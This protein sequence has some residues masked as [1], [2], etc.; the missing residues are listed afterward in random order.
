MIREAI[1]QEKSS[2]RLCRFSLRIVPYS[3]LLQAN[4]DSFNDSTPFSLPLPVDFT[5]VAD[6]HHEDKKDFVPDLVNDAVVSY[7]QA[8]ESALSLESLDSRRTR[9]CC[10]GENTLVYSLPVSARKASKVTLCSGKDCNAVGQ[11]SPS[12]FRACS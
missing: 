1:K 11:S 2:L 12:S 4:N 5:A 9:I 10:K 7:P 3:R 8:E 6:L